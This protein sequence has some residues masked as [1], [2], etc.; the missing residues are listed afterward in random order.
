MAG[1]LWQRGKVGGYR[2]Y[3]S[4]ADITYVDDYLRDTLGRLLRLLQAA[5]LTPSIAISPMRRW[6]HRTKQRLNLSFTISMETGPDG[7]RT[8]PAP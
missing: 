7:K 1:L 5:A 4:A 2:D 8:L 6:S 3:L